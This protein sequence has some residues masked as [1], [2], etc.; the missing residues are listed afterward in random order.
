MTHEISKSNIFEFLKEESIVEEIM[1]DKIEIYET[2][3]NA[4]LKKVTLTSLNQ[5]SK[6]W[7]INTESK[8]LS[9]EGKKVEKVIFEQMDSGILNVIMVELK[10]G[11]VSNQSR[12]LSKFSNSLSW[13]Y[14]LLNLLHEK[15]KIHVFGILISQD[16]SCLWNEK[17]KLRIFSSTSIRYIK[18]SFYTTDNE[19]VL[20]IGRVL[21]VED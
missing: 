8:L 3:K 7:T 2:E 9:P 18:R 13:V 4:K 16:S 11:N 14:L 6:Y 1:D 10:S 21:R 12:V 5:K 17:S 19:F 15:Q 20:D